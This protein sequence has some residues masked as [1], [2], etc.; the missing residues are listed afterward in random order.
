MYLR[1]V[2]EGS[3]PLRA[4]IVHLRERCVARWLQRSLDA[5]QREAAAAVVVHGMHISSTAV[6]LMGT[7]LSGEGKRMREHAELNGSD[8]ERAVRTGTSGPSYARGGKGRTLTHRER[9]AARL[10]RIHSGN[11]T[12]HSRIAHAHNGS[13]AAGNCMPVV[14]KAVGSAYAGCGRF[15]GVCA[16]GVRRSAP[17]ANT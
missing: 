2:A 14:R 11:V 12:G 4:M 10:Y 9:Q 13:R 5:V 7:R 8:R 1:R 17:S 15:L 16:G 3:T 6:V